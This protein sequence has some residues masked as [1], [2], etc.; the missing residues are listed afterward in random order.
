MLS[1]DNLMQ[2]N[3]KLNVSAGDTLGSV[4][5]SSLH[6]DLGFPVSYSL[7]IT[8]FADAVTNFEASS[9]ILSSGYRYTSDVEVSSYT[10]PVNQLKAKIAYVPDF[11][12]ATAYFVQEG[13]L[14]TVGINPNETTNNQTAVMKKIIDSFE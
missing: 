1:G 7:S 8:L 9:V 11:N 14:Y 13:V 10:S 3:I 2:K 5:I 12:S 4:S 6:K